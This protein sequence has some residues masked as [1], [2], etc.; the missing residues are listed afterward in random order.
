MFFKDENSLLR[1]DF[2]MRRLIISLL[3]C[4]LM[5]TSALAI[6]TW[7]DGGAAV[8][9]VLNGI[10]KNPLG[11]SVTAATD[12]IMNDTYWEIGGGGT[13]VSTVVIELAGSSLVDNQKFGVYELANPLTLVELF[14][15]TATAGSTTTLSIMALG[16]VFV[17]G[18]DS[19][20]NFA[21][22]QFG[23]YLDTRA[24]TGG[25]SGGLWYSDTILNSDNA[26]HMAAYQG[27]GDIVQ[28][29]PFSPGPWGPSE[30]ILAWEGKVIP[31][32]DRDYDDFVV[33]VESVNPTIPAPGAILLGSMGVG[34]VGWLKRRRSL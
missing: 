25:A 14:D 28:I 12:Y 13:S 16:D 1:G 20:V 29:L 7:S 21:T 4:A 5:A 8:Q 17:G 9:S 34:L 6:P 10:T 22:N 31:D 26:D 23:F 3:M 11:S 33:M 19:G 15:G 18:T 24:A 27:V 2:E 32:G 30:Y